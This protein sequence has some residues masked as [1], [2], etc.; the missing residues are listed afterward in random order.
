MKD[1]KTTAA[2]IV[3][4]AL[5]AGA[6]YWLSGGMD[7]QTALQAMG[8]AA[9]GV[10]AGDAKKVAAPA[11]VAAVSA[12]N[13]ATGPA[14]QAGFSRVNL[15]LPL[16]LCL[17]L[18]SGVGCGMFQNHVCDQYQ[19]G[20]SR[21]CDAAN[22]TGVNLGYID[23][24]VTLGAAA[25]MEL[26]PQTGAADARALC[27]SLLQDLQSPGITGAQLLAAIKTEGNKHPGL[28]MLSA[29]FAANLSTPQALKPAD[30]T[31]MHDFLVQKFQLFGGTLDGAGEP[32]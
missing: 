3:A 16:A 22:Q 4:A 27:K 28:V 32:L 11:A 15:L 19:P 7:A 29:A 26:H 8:L 2:G 25:Y 9:L 30:L 6:H 18:V 31:I 14:G 21:L 23:T 5:T 13:T 24:G 10:L 12:A 20:Q 17:M 1:W